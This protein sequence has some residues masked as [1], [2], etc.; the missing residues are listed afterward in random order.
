MRSTQPERYSCSPGQHDLSVQIRRLKRPLMAKVWLP[1]LWASAIPSIWT[2]GRPN[3]GQEA[4]R[5]GSPNA[6]Y[7]DKFEIRQI[8]FRGCFGILSS[9]RNQWIPKLEI[10]SWHTIWTP[11]LHYL[12]SGR[13]RY[14]AGKEGLRIR[15]IWTRQVLWKPSSLLSQGR[16]GARQGGARPKAP[17]G[18]KYNPLGA[19]GGV[20][21]PSI[22]QRAAGTK[23]K[24]GEEA[25]SR[26]K[27]A[28]CL[29]DGLGHA[30]AAMVGPTWWS[31]GGVP[32][33][34]P[35]FHQGN[36][37]FYIRWWYKSFLFFTLIYIDECFLY[38]CS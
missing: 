11:N 26:R 17:Q 1:K 36:C 6:S 10:I 32:E 14:D 5:Y 16:C 18:H 20:I 34:M 9:F 21:H 25:D 24:H 29:G 38:M 28:S 19:Q 22:H 15:K 2:C 13:G 31:H 30:L 8:M 37:T 3:S 7:A 23:E 33:P 4:R 27:S 35:W 12:E